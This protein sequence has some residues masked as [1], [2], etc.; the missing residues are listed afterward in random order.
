MLLVFVGSYAYWREANNV[1]KTLFTKPQQSARQRNPFANDKDQK[2]TKAGNDKIKLKTIINISKK[3]EELY[4]DFCLRL[5]LHL[6]V[7]NIILL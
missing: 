2:P 1:L 7:I 6:Q 4:Y 5:L 3:K